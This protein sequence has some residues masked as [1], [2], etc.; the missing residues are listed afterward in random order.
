M[1]EKVCPE[2]IQLHFPGALALT[3]ECTKCRDCA[4]NCPVKAI[5]FPWWR[6]PQC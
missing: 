2:N 3:S 4:E 6:R 5:T 1:C